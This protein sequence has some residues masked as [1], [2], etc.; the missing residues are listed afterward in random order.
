[1]ALGGWKL[2]VVVNG[3]A[4]SVAGA[5][6]VTANIK[7]SNGWVHLL[8]DVIYMDGKYCRL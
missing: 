6:V 4:V 3:T 8:D 7:A 2:P 1:M 5:K